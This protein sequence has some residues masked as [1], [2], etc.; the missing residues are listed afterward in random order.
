MHVN[1][2]AY[3][4]DGLAIMRRSAY[5]AVKIDYVQASGTK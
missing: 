1:R 2:S 4:P 5:G 3:L